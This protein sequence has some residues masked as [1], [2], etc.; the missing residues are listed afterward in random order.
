MREYERQSQN[1]RP[2]RAG[3]AVRRR[4]AEI[5]LPHQENCLFC[6]YL[7]HRPPEDAWRW[8][9]N[10]TGSAFGPAQQ[11]NFSRGPEY[12]ESGEECIPSHAA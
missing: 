5:K 6:A 7:D 12:S 3:P 2:G 8:R 11:G 4:M 9:P 10:A 1:Y